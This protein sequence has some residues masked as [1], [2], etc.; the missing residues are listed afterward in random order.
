[1]GDNE[2]GQGARGYSK[3]RRRI[4]HNRPCIGSMASE[5]LSRIGSLSQ[6]SGVL[7]S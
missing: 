3:K 7:G 1:M 6:V 2:R 4:G 5:S